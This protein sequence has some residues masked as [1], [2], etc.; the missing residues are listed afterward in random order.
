AASLSSSVPFVVIDTSVSGATSRSIATS[1]GSSARTVGSPPVSLKD[2]TPS[3]TNTRASRAISS[4]R[5]ISSRGSHWSPSAGMQ[6]VQRKLHRSVTEI[7]RSSATLPKESTR[8]SGWSTPPGYPG[9][10]QWTHG[11]GGGDGLR[12]G[13][14]G[15]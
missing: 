13:V 5:R 8:G 9:A 12:R 10:Q 11:R 7:R 1:L 6:Y 14:G 3:E 2:R 4:N 15:D